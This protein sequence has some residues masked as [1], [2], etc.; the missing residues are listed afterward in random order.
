MLKLWFLLLILVQCLHS[1]VACPTQCY[2]S[3]KKMTCANA[4]MEESD[5]AS[6]E[7]PIG[8]NELV[9]K[10]NDLESISESTMF[11]LRHLEILEISKNK[12]SKIPPYT[13]RGFLKLRKLI[14][15]ENNIAELNE[16]S[17]IG[18]GNLVYLELQHNKIST[19][20]S[21]ILDKLTSIYSIRMEDNKLRAIEND[22]FSPLKSLRHL[23]LTRNEITTIADRAF[24]GM[25]MN[26]L[27]LA[28]NKISVIPE[29]AF[30]DF[31]I[32]KKILMLDNPLDCTCKNAMN[33]K[34]NFQHLG[35][36]IWGYCG[37]P[38]H[39]R[40]HIMQAHEELIE[41]SLCD[42]NP[43]KNGGKCTGNKTSFKCSCQE[44]YKG[45]HC[46][47][48]V[49]EGYRSPIITRQPE[50]FQRPDSVALKQINRTEY[51]IVKEE[52]N[53]ED[54]AKKLKILYAM[55]AFEFIVIICFVV[56][57]MWK[58]YEEWKLQKRYENDKGRSIFLY[59]EK[60][61]QLAKVLVEEN[62][63]FPAEL[64]NMI[65]NGPVPV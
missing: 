55:C 63:E 1:V 52:I 34:M 29:S 12:I 8:I 33:Y 14:L 36:K 26:I 13:F 65:L 17:F 23:F 21:G 44:R 62:E 61:T 39:I 31:K 25:K 57:F 11:N 42:L 3:D 51:V 38:Y 32:S 47:V 46:E 28:T 35:Y 24:S 16:G 30:K 22:V 20:P 58:R 6:L 54:D 27:G 2:C 59:D 7:I 53:N 5:L 56:Y 41:C 45:Q 43:C 9:L 49:C 48:N 64:K 19:L 18:L 10:S 37:S 4:L 40:S 50:I 15:N 60:K